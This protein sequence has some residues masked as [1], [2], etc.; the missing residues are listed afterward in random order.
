MSSP[1]TILAAMTDVTL[2]LQRIQG[3]QVEA[4]DDLIPAV[5]DELFRLAVSK[6][7]QERAEHK[8]FV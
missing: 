1:Q 5:Y 6:I 2:I 7:K 8:Q 3:G 4:N